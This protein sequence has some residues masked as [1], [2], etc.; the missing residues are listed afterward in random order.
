MQF[1]S[2]IFTLLLFTFSIACSNANTPTNSTSETKDEK[3]PKAVLVKEEV[4]EKESPIEVQEEASV[5]KVQEKVEVKKAPPVKKEQKS[6]VKKVA[7]EAV[8]KAS[9]TKPEKAETPN[10]IDQEKTPQVEEK[11]EEQAF[12]HQLFDELLQK[13]VSASGKVNYK[14]IKADRSKLD[15]YIS[16]L[17]QTA[18]QS[19]WPRKEKMAYLINAYNAYTIQLI[20]DNYP[21]SSITNLH[22]GSPWKVKLANLGGK[23]YSL[24]QIENEI[25]RPQFKDARIHFAV[26]CAAKSCPPI[27]NRAWTAQNLNRYF[28]Q[29]AR[30]FIN[31]SAFNQISATEVKISKIFEWYAVDFGNIIDYLN[32]YSKTTI[33]SNAKVT[34]MEYNWALNQ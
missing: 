9:E 19:R 11:S 22:G 29:Q 14:G 5:E 23:K 2:K 7:K 31:N 4:K 15:A 18:L 34:Y 21:V 25:L 10:P 3:L 12:S 33:Q 32:K 24:D 27:L 20:I 13:Y 30:K 28:E 26:N 17:S 16:L 6:K 1:Y 8:T